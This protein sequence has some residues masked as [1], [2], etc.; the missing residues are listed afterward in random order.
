MAILNPT[1]LDLRT[2]KDKSYAEFEIIEKVLSLDKSLTKNWKVYYSY[3]FKGDA[4]DSTYQKRGYEIDF[5]FLI[6][7]YGIF[8]MEVKGGIISKRN[9]KLYSS[10]SKGYEFEI[11][12]VKQARENY[13]TLDKYFKKKYKFNLN[14]FISSYTVS[15]PDMESKCGLEFDDLDYDVFYKDIDLYDYIIGLTG[16]L[17]LRYTDKQV[18]TQEDIDKLSEIIQ[19]VDFT[20]SISEKE[21]IYNMNLLMEE[22][23]KEQVDIYKNILYDNPR[24]LIKGI[25][26]SGKTAFAIDLYKHY[27]AKGKNVLFLV[28]NKLLNTKLNESD[29]VQVKL[30][31]EFIESIYNKDNDP[32]NDNLTFD[33]KKDKWF[34]YIRKVN[35]I[36][37]YDCIIIDECQDIEYNPVIFKLLNKLLIGG[38]KNGS[39]YLFYDENQKLFL[40]NDSLCLFEGLKYN[41]YRP[42]LINLTKNIR[43]SL[44]IA[45]FIK[46]C[47]ETKTIDGEIDFANLFNESI[48][49]AYYKITNDLLAKD[50][51]IDIIN[52]L[53]K[54]HEI[55]NKQITILKDKKDSNV[56]KLLQDKYGTTLVPYSSNNKNLTYST[57]RSFKGLDNDVIIYIHDNKYSKYND[58]YVAIT[59]A[60]HYF[61][62]IDCVNKENLYFKYDEVNNQI[63]DKTYNFNNNLSILELIKLYELDN[64]FSNKTYD[65]ALKIVSDKKIDD[66]EIDKK[67][68]TAS[69]KGRRIYQTVILKN[70]FKFCFRCNCD[71]FKKGIDTPCKHCLALLLKLKD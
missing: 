24:C 66:I 62:C 59:R 30:I 64:K 20:Y 8:I 60:K 57:V 36:E 43:N 15:F 48:N 45:S 69:I 18:P 53:I 14:D 32:L 16:F 63:S 56:L 7:Y 31:Y 3:T 23:T 41:T 13:F 44:E 67:Q 21:Y 40:Q 12:P 19:G 58:E 50:K 29:N 1:N 27:A 42:T 4:F 61:Y 17:K 46:L 54:K 68:I 37:T 65:K 34:K 47:N 26:G 9:G 38:M 39:W 22:Q 55:K 35:L 25:A 33:E 28:Y 71:Y 2:V 10:N 11:E 52:N 49:C 70:S 6:P 5:I 51:I